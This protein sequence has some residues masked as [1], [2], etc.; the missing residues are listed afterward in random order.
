[1]TVMV[2]CKTWTSSMILTKVSTSLGNAWGN[3][4]A[5]NSNCVAF[6]SLLY[7]TDNLIFYI[8]LKYQLLFVNNLI[9]TEFSYIF[10]VVLVILASSKVLFLLK[11]KKVFY[12]QNAFL[13]QLS[14]FVLL[15][16][17]LLLLSWLI[18]SFIIIFS[19]LILWLYVVFVLTVKC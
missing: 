4:A 15:K 14:F 7:F 19:L 16:F 6:F 13:Y 11:L 17:C 1:M 8:E 18:W 2:N 9:E 10:S 12:A 5:R 3:L